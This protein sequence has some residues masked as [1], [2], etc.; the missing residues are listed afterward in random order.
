MR[1]SS[2]HISTNSKSTYLVWVCNKQDKEMMM[3]LI[4]KGDIPTRG[5]SKMQ[6][7]A[8]SVHLRIFS[9]SRCLR[10]A[11]ARSYI[12]IWQFLHSGILKS[13][14]LG[15]SSQQSW[16]NKMSNQLIITTMLPQQLQ[17][18]TATLLTKPTKRKLT[19]SL[20]QAIWKHQ[21]FVEYL[22]RCTTF[23]CLWALCD[24]V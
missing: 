14:N 15:V 5:M 7:V 19:K 2:L 8:L 12:I 10:F 17:Q 11:R 16:N 18:T 13:L 3:C 24:C 21:R 6:G 1:S 9:V 20:E 22:I 23:S 4:R